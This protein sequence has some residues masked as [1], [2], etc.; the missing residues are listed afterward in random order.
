V[1]ATCVY[2]ETRSRLYYSIKLLSYS[3]IEIRIAKLSL[4]RDKNSLCNRDGNRSLRTFYRDLNP[5][6]FF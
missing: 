5:Q 6:N 2:I 1:G 4:Y 3:Y